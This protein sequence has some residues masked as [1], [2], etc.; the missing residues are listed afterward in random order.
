MVEEGE[1]TK[2]LPL[3]SGVPPQLTENH[4][5]VAPVPN[6]PPATLKVVVLPA[7][8]GFGTAEALTGAVDTLFTV[9]VMDTQAVVL[10]VPSA[11]T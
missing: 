5:H 9:T 4:C 8:T 2:E 1:T 7:H 11:L 6:N 10:Q 3:P